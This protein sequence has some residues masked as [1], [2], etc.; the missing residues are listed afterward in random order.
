MSFA[1][2]TGVILLISCPILLL[3]GIP[4]AI[5]IAV[6]SVLAVL[7]AL[8]IDISLITSV[9]RIFTGMDSFYYREL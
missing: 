3:L 9:Q 1:V 5:S 2:T 4:I 6:S 7:S 8:P